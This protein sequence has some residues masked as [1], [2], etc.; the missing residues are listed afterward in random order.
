MGVLRVLGGLGGRGWVVGCTMG[1]SCQAKWRCCG[2][3]TGALA[4]AGT[5][6]RHGLGGCH[7]S[8]PR[9]MLVVLCTSLP[10]PHHTHTRT[11][12]H[13]PTHLPHPPVISFTRSTMSSSVLTTTSSAL[14]R[15][16]GRR[17]EGCCRSAAGVCGVTDPAV[18]ADT[19]A[20]PTESNSRCLDNSRCLGLPHASWCRV[21]QACASWCQL[22]AAAV[23]QQQQ[24]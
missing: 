22:V 19:R 6:G 5:R 13:P 21:L 7:K 16:H 15:G 10:P 4:V 23:E 8:A 12:T 1:S 14:E 24:R 17:Q 18:P 3:S 9:S 20:V 11:P 2:A